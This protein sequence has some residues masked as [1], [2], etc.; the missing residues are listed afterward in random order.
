MIPVVHRRV[1]QQLPGEKRT[2]TLDLTDWPHIWDEILRVASVEDRTPE[3]Q[4]R[5]WLRKNLEAR[6][7]RA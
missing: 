7:E 4:V 3:L 5:H 1:G 6:S 2:L